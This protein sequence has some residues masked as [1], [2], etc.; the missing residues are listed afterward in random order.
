MLTLSLAV[1]FD[2][3]ALGVFAATSAE[4]CVLVSSLA[5]DKE[6]AIFQA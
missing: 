4:P 2:F 5:K 3:G 1:D 6:F